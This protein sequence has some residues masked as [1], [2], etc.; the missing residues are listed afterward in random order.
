M[1]TFDRIDSKLPSKMFETFIL[2]SILRI[3]KSPDAGLV[4]EV[5]IPR[6]VFLILS[7]AILWKAKFH[8]KMNLYHLLLLLVV[9]LLIHEF[10]K[11]RSQNEFVL[12]PSTKSLP[13]FTLISRLYKVLDC[14][15]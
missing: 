12:N 10:S 13:E 4:K 2:L 1:I 3:V 6:V 5:T 15:S 11:P 9:F 7:V 14:C 8:E